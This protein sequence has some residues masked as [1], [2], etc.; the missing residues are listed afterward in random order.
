MYSLFDTV[1]VCPDARC[2]HVATSLLWFGLHFPRWTNMA[3][4]LPASKATISSYDFEQLVLSKCRT[5]GAPFRTTVSGGSSTCVVDFAT[6]EARH[7]CHA[8]FDE[9]KTRFGNW[10]RECVC[11]CAKVYVLVT[12]CVGISHTA[13]TLSVVPPRDVSWCLLLLPPLPTASTTSHLPSTPS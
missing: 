4:R 12:D 3:P 8:A 10:N 6:K 2:F 7:G 1:C 5:T 9:F 11:I 13:T